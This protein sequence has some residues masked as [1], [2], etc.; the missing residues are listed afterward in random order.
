M[1]RYVLAALKRAGHEAYFDHATDCDP[2][3][4]EA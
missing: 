2:F 1:R 3:E 4:V